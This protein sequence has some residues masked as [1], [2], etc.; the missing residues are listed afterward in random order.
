M[1]KVSVFREPELSGEYVV[2]G[3]G[4]VNFPLLGRVPVEGKTVAEIEKHIEA[5]LAKDYLVNPSLSVRVA[6][7]R[8]QQVQLLGAVMKPGSYALRGPTT[9]LE[10]ISQGGGIDP[11]EGGAKVVVLRPRKGKEGEDQFFTV[12]LNVLLRGA[13]LSANIPLQ[14][15]DTVYVPRADSIFVFG[16]VKNP[17]PY[18]IQDR[19]VTLAEAVSLAGGLTRLAAP[20]RTRVV[21]LEGG[22]ERV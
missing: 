21:R 3:D 9:V 7:Y 11:R 12:N 6:E 16:Q 18:K 4:T 10:I 1:L 14:G 2:A 5:F 17:G 20:N 15:D 19:K 22:T 13:D 8:S